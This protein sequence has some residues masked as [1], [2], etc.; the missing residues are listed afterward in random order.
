[1]WW[2]P[3]S[4]FMPP[5][6][7]RARA[8]FVP[9]PV[10]LAGCHDASLCLRYEVE[11]G[12]RGRRACRRRGCCELPEADTCGGGDRIAPLSGDDSRRHTQDPVAEPG[13][14]GRRCV[15]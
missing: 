1:M 5:P 4:F 3:S 9:R 13:L 8:G 14:G 10:T 7:T 6:E 11:V 15:G 2:M 12:S